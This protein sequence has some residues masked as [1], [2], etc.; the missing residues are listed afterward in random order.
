MFYR[1]LA[2]IVLILHFAFVLFV[3]LGAL[4]IFRWPRL[5][6]FHLP[7]AAWGTII[8]FARWRCPLTPLEVNLRRLGGAGGYANG[9]VDHYVGSIL[10][11]GDLSRAMHITLGVVVLALN[12]VIY[13]ILWRRRRKQLLPKRKV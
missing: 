13:V 3:V 4:F 8:E 5:L 7:A 1:F 9:F 12:I 10:Y 11:P 2:D 6:W